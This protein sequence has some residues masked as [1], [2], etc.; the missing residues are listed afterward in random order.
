MH[1]TLACLCLLLP[2]AAALA[3]SPDK[4]ALSRMAGCET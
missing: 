1:R 3:Q 4:A 2:P